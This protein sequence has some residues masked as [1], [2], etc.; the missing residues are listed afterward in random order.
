MEGPLYVCLHPFILATT[1]ALEFLLFWSFSELIQ[2]LECSR[3]YSQ[4]VQ[5]VLCI[6]WE[7]DKCLLKEWMY[8]TH[9]P[10]LYYFCQL[11]ISPDKDKMIN[12]HW[13]S[14][15]LYYISYPL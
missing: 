8:E 11:P 15:I 10:H 13:L 5:N 7:L 1:I 14:G 4:K 2:A 6:W 3:L 9:I 12:S